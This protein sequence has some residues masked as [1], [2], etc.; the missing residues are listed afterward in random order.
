[1]IFAGRAEEAADKTFGMVIFEAP[2]AV[3]AKK[4]MEGGP[5]AKAGVMTSEPQPYLMAM[6]RSP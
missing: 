1:M 2:D 5:A 4:F 3:A 6:Q